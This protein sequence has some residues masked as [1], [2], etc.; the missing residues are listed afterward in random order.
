MKKTLILSLV[1]ILIGLAGCSKDI[2]QAKLDAYFETLA[3]NNKFMG[4]V[5]V[6]RNGQVIYAKTVGF[7]DME[8]GLKADENSKYRIASIS[9]TF[10]AVLIF[11]AI[12]DGELNL[13]QTIDKFFPEIKNADKMTISHLLYHRSG[14]PN[15]NNYFLQSKTVQE[16]IEKL[17]NAESDFE[18]DTQ[19]NYGNTS[20]VLLSYILEKIYQ[21][22]YSEIL[23]EK[24]TKPVGLKNTCCG[25]TN[26]KDNECRSYK[27]D[28]KMESE[29]TSIKYGW[30]TDS[31][32][33]ISGLLGGAGI[34]SNAVDLALFSDALFNGKLISTYSLQQMKTI[35][36]DYGMGLVQMS[37]DD[38]T[39]FGH[40]G[41]WDGF[42]ST[43]VYFTD[44]NISFAFTANG[45]N[46]SRDNIIRAVLNV[47]Y[48]KSFEIPEFKTSIYRA[49]NEDLD[50]C[51]G[52]YSSEE[53]PEK[54]T[55]IKIYNTLFG[56]KA[57][58]YVPL[59]A[60]EKDKFEFAEEGIILE[61]NPIDKAMAFTEGGKTYTFKKN[62]KPEIKTCAFYV[63]DKDLDKYLG[64]YSSEEFPTKAT[65]IKA[66]NTLFVRA[67][68][69]NS[70]ML[71]Q[72]TEK[73]KF[74]FAEEN[75]IF[76]FYPADKTMTVKQGRGIF[77]F[78]RED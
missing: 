23:E 16:V 59:V 28:W 71:L 7:A 31:Y 67:P 5:A 34:V 1:V 15:D 8:Q 26:V 4:S 22:S 72:A 42:S 11:K 58:S 44:S 57:N 40:E 74:E 14:I 41:G 2:D 78:V 9:K 37:F 61:F 65:I 39:G 25:K 64:V 46:Y 20:F 32:V 30:V 56:T 63:A 62:E 35:K 38:K 76:E 69:R 6:S 12:E 10:T 3:D 51:A 21:K 33:D 68:G 49:T 17:S 13:N 55:L 24:I 54:I 77:N 19:K 47:I 73:D 75:L 52:V 36:D 66:C 45:L 29:T 43:F 60:T 50:N 53:I 70:L 27:Y 18:P 48:N